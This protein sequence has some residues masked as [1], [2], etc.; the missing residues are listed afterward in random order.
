MRPPGLP[1]PSASSRVTNDAKTRVK[2]TARTGN[3]VSNLLVARPSRRCGVYHRAAPCADPL[4]A[5]RDE[6][7][8]A[9]S[10]AHGAEAGMRRLEPWDPMHLA[11]NHRARISTGTARH[12][13]RL[14]HGPAI[15]ILTTWDT[16]FVKVRRKRVVGIRGRAVVAR[17]R[18]V[19]GIC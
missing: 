16:R 2:S 15:A 19:M 9:V 14:S 10:N 12:V 3:R 6:V 17:H 8:I 7:V 5:P 11:C 13:A 1:A 18:L 4:A